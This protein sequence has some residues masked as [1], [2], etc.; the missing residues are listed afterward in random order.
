MC[1]LDI[2][3]SSDN[4]STIY[5]KLST[6]VEFSDNKEED[7]EVLSLEHLTIQ[8]RLKLLPHMDV[9]RCQ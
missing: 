5:D 6:I 3:T 8:A 4:E 2:E 1:S 7:E 9:G